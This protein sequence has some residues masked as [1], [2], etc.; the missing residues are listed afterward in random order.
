MSRMWVQISRPQ[1]ECKDM[2]QIAN[3][4][5]DL[6]IYTSYIGISFIFLPT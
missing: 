4:K 6:Y 2:I 1:S 5:D 3:K